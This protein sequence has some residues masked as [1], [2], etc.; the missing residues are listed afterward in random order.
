MQKNE[1]RPSSHQIKKSTEEE[2][3]QNHKPLEEDSRL[4]KNLI[5]MTP[6]A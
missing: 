2:S 1:S 3:L 4:G 5:D 6:K